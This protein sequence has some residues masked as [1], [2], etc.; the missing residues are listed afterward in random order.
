[1]WSSP[2]LV[3]WCE[4]N[5]LYGPWVAEAWNTASSLVLVVLGVLGMFRLHGL[6]FRLGMFGLA[7][8][9]AG[10][11]LFH[12][13]LVRLAQAADELPMVWLGLACVW[14][15]A[16]REKPPG[17]GRVL[18]AGFLLFGALFTIAYAVVPW[19]FTLFL[20]VYGALVAWL[21]LRTAQ[22]TLGAPFPIKRAAL[23]TIGAYLGSFFVFWV[24][25]HVVLAC[26]HPL[27][28]VQLHAWWHVGA[29]IGTY[30]WWWW[31][32]LDRE[33]V[34]GRHPELGA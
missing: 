32:Y 33:R 29:G 10:S 17:E 21:A 24:P 26:D 2:A 20:G 5:Y 12:G 7:G 6:R 27:Q 18:A 16:D 3:D 25:E 11:A 23:A 22:L 1:M 14:T 15:I 13:S 9:G 8:V 34:L 30:A 4:P 19:A 28:A 31:A